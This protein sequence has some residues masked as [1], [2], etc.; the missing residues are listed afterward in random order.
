MLLKN[1]SSILGLCL[2]IP[3][4]LIHK[5]FI[6]GFFYKKFFG[7][8]YVFNFLGKKL[9]FKI[10]N[11]KS[12]VFY[13]QF[14][15]KTYEYN[16]FFILKKWI[17]KKN[18]CLVF[19]GGIGFNAAIAH[20][21]SGN[22]IFVSEINRSIIDDLKTN[23]KHNKIASTLVSKNIIF[24]KKKNNKF[25]YQHDNFL[26]SSFFSKSNKKYEVESVFF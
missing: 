7:N 10:P 12:Y 1:I 21:I 6:F 17:N 18:R 13:S 2:L 8:L 14:L 5:N 24:E 22:K 19:G 20:L 16:D 3:Y 15:F 11:V 9:E 25:F 23:L 4:Y 26:C